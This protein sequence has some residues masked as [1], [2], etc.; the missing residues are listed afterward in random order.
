MP[1]DGVFRRGRYRL[2]TWLR[3]HEPGWLYARWPIPKGSTD[4]G[5]HEFYNSDDVVDRCYHCEVGLRPHLTIH[6]LPPE[7]DAGT[8]ERGRQ[9]H[10]SGATDEDL[11]Q[12]FKDAGLTWIRSIR[13]F[14]FATDKPLGESKRAVHLSASWADERPQIDAFHDELEDWARKEVDAPSPGSHEG[15]EEDS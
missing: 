1:G 5:N 10:A 6:T 4:C 9:L 3:L 8:I 14:H 7:T 11:I 15:R 12:M 2:R 13:A